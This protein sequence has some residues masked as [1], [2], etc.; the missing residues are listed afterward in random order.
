MGEPERIRF[1]TPARNITYFLGKMGDW[2]IP[3]GPYTLTQGIVGIV[4]L[5][6]SLWLK[7]YWGTGNIILDFVLSLAIAFGACYFSGRIN[8]KNANPIALTLGVYSFYCA[9]V[10]GNRGD[11]KVS[12]KNT[13]ARVRRWESLRYQELGV[14]Q[15]G[16]VAAEMSP[17]VEESVAPTRNGVVSSP[18]ESSPAKTHQL[19]KIQQMLAASAQRKDLANG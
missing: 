18:E 3:G 19:T 5:M 13:K 11:V 16:D 15:V 4:S 12:I 8:F 9:P 2:V 1:Y 6:V 10:A 14:H 7:D 17:C